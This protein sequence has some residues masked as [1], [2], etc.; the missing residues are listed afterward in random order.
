MNEELEISRGKED[1][2]KGKFVI[3]NDFKHYTKK[4]WGRGDLVP[5]SFC[6]VVYG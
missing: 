6:S 4:T 3:A 1:K 2:C 5:P